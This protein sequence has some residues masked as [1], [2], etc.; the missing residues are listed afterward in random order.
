MK[1]SRSLS[2]VPK[3]KPTGLASTT[4]EQRRKMDARKLIKLMGP[5]HIKHPQYKHR[6]GSLVKLEN[7]AGRQPVFEASDETF[8]SLCKRA[9]RWMAQ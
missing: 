4:W 2:E 1:T 3:S 6:P 5:L 8:W 9:L 7:L